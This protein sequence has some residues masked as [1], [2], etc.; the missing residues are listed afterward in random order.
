MRCSGLGVP[1][2]SVRLP[3]KKAPIRFGSELVYNYSS[4]PLHTQLDSQQINGLM[5]K[6]DSVAQR[7][8]ASN[9][10]FQASVEKGF[11]AI[12]A[13]LQASKLTSP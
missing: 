11:Q 9:K 12:V 7:M 10:A 1:P 8:E 6:L 13:A 4:N 5:A 2:V 3:E